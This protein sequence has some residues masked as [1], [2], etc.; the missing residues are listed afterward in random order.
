MISHA[1]IGPAMI[2]P[3]GL[4]PGGWDRFRFGYGNKI[5]LELA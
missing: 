4:G 1:G 2:S 5:P 3:I